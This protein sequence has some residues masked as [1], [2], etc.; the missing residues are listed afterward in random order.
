LSRS[1]LLHWT[2]FVCLV[3]NPF[4]MDYLVVARG[5]G[6]ALGFFLLAIYLLART[7][8]RR[9]EPGDREILNYAAG[10]SACVGV[11]LCANFSFGYANAFL[12]LVG[13][14]LWSVQERKRGLFAW[15]RLL[16]A[17]AVPAS[18]ILLFVAGPVLADFPRAQLFWGARSLRDTWLEIYDASF[19]E[20]N[21]YLVNSTVA[22][23]LSKLKPHLVRAEVRFTFLSAVL[24]VF[25]G[26]LR[27]AA[28]KFTLVLAGALTSVLFLTLLAHWLQFR[29]LQI[30]L[31]FE[32]TSL[33]LVP[34]GTAIVGVVLSVKP[35]NLLDRAAWG[36]GIAVMFII[37]VYFLGTLR[38]SY[39]REWRI[40]ADLRSAFPVAAELSRR[41]GVRDFPSDLNYT[42]T[43]NFYRILNQVKHLDELQN[44]DKMPSGKA[45]YVI[46]EG[47][48]ADFIRTEGLKVA[49]HG[50]VSDVVV[51]YKQDAVTGQ[52]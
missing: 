50:K 48:Y 10:F 5:Y 38:D 1:V 4:I 7:L 33:F 24:M 47:L 9:H 39:F 23:F 40:C 27:S 18:A 34:L 52:D 28:I 12:L 21:R 46:P 45:M 49:Y 15:A 51:V 13:F 43:L 11:S 17:C 22:D 2:L 35:S 36:F 6:L 32:R 8:V 42:G 16:L 3:Y 25:T 30:P 19:G 37:S 31:P 29:F 14:V 26:R 20:F 44:F 41:A